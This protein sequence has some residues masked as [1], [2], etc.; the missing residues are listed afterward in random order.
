MSQEKENRGFNFDDFEITFVSNE[1]NDERG[2]AVLANDG[3]KDF[4]YFSI[5]MNKENP[6]YPAL[7]YVEVASKE[8]KR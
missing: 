7:H 2:C 8:L 3:K 1:W 4:W 5:Q 6:N